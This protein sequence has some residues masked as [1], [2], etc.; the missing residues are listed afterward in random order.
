VTEILRFYYYNARAGRRIGVE[1]KGY[2]W[3]SP[4]D[5]KPHRATLA[6]GT[7]TH[8]LEYLPKLCAACP[9]K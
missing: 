4:L 8:H 6:G 3:Q 7:Y 2:R 1:K 9:Y 5:R